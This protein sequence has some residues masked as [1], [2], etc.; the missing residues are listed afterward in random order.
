MFSYLNLLNRVMTEGDDRQTRNGLRRTL[1]GAQLRFNL[2]HAFP[3][4]TTR[5]I[6]PKNPFAE[7]PW[8]LNGDTKLDFLHRHNVH[9]WDKNAKN[10]DIGLGYGKQWRD[11][12][13]ID[14]IAYALNLLRTDPTSTRMVV[15]AWNPEDL[16]K[17]A[18]PP[19]HT[20]FQLHS[21][22][23]SVSLQVYMRSVDLVIGLPSNIAGYALLTHLFAKAT[24]KEPRDLIFSLGNAHVYEDHF[25]GVREQLGR[26]PLPLPT[27]RV[28]GEVPEDLYGVDP[29]QLVLENYKHHSPIKFE[30]AV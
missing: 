4:V 22:G 6:P 18:L 25:A 10:G 23:S 1:E 13:G 17:M 24:G 8:M 7:I 30:M 27:F 28:E 26:T 12:R 20:L 5:Y 16:E 15:S 9:I 3:M 11:F 14:Q 19:C 21:D 2:R 29:A